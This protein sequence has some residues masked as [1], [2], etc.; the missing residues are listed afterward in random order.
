MPNKYV[1]GQYP[2]YIEEGDG[3]YVSDDQY[4]YIDYPC[5]LGAILLGHSIDEVNKAIIE[6]LVDGTL[7]TL[8]HRLETELASKLNL[9]LNDFNKY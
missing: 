7:F 4:S 9:D 2:I 3:C 5:S 6:Q 1:E 8:P